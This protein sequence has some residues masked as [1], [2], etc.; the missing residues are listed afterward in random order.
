MIET[1]YA[2]PERSPC[3]LAGNAKAERQGFRPAAGGAAARFILLVSNREDKDSKKG[4]ARRIKSCSASG[5]GD[6][7]KCK[8]IDRERNAEW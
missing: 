8:L 1:S 7:M 5:F 2:T 6:F 4:T 3:R